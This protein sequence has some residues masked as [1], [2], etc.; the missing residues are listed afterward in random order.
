MKKL[1][2]VAIFALSII[3]FGSCKSDCVCTAKEDGEK[4]GSETFKKLSSSECSD[5][6]KEYQKQADEDVSISCVSE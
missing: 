6:E 4:I 1:L 2:L 5:K 3:G